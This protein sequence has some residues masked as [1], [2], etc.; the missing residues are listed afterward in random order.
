MR[1]LSKLKLKS[2]I[3]E[4]P[5]FHS[6]DLGIKIYENN[7][8]V[9]FSKIDQI[10]G[11]DL[12]NLFK[13]YGPNIQWND[14][15][16]EK[17]TIWEVY[18]FKWLLTQ[19]RRIQEKIISEYLKTKCGYGPLYM[20]SMEVSIRL[21]NLTQ[22]G[23]PPKELEIRL[24]NDYKFIYKNLEVS[25]N[26]KLE[27]FAYNHYLFGLL[28]IY[29]YKKNNRITKYLLQREIE[30]QFIDG[31]HFEG[32][33]H[34][35]YFTYIAIK[36]YAPELL[37]NHV[38]N[39][40]LYFGD[41]DSGWT[42]IHNLSQIHQQSRTFL[43][44]DF[45]YIKLG[46]FNFAS[47]IQISEPSG[48]THND[49]ESINLFYKGEMIIGNGASYSY[50]NESRMEERNGKYI[51]GFHSKENKSITDKFSKLKQINPYRFNYNESYYQYLS[52]SLAREVYIDEEKLL[53]QDENK[54]KYRPYTLIL[55]CSE[56]IKN[57]SGFYHT[58]K[59]LQLET[60]NFSCSNHKVS[61]SYNNYESIYYL[62]SNEK[63][64]KILIWQQA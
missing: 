21:I 36:T 31:I 13:V 62:T 41:N 16:L 47:H 30:T 53:I 25:F 18:R 57:A 12:S 43:S 3:A 48:H 51:N 63:K 2:K 59:N 15:E 28:G 23:N 22:I 9:N 20:N 42:S 11:K 26:S 6:I 39:G 38:F 27:R 24:K 60:S 37:K 58:K 46:D 61:F 34:Y 7:R 45:H 8:L 35:H 14:A 33:G 50:T 17:K 29:Y 19:E 49:L 1:R 32:S 54:Y 10:D 5:D 40:R 64:I 55:R 44:N 56:W 52:K 4:K